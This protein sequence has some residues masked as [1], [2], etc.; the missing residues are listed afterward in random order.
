MNIG[1][2]GTGIAYPLQISTSGGIRASS[3]VQRIEESIRIILGTQYGERVM[4][5][6]FGCNLKS[7]VFAP[8]NEATANL[9][10]YYVE[11]GLTQWEPRIEVFEVLVEN[12]NQHGLLL[13][14]IH[15]RLRATQEVRSTLVPFSL[16]AP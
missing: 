15:Y 4:R 7:L 3:G 16:E 1:F 11:Q 14:E 2:F 5:P 12:D 8:N 10:R 13:I 9:A 6:N